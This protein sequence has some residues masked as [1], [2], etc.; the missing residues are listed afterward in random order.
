[1]AL[2][3]ENPLRGHPPEW[4][5]ALIFLK[6]QQRRDVQVLLDSGTVLD[7]RSKFLAPDPSLGFLGC[8]LLTVALKGIRESN[9]GILL[10][11]K[12]SLTGVNT[13]HCPQL[14]A[15]K[16]TGTQEPKAGEPT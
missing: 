8:M 4:L 7:L 6:G 16:Q 1:M 9:S 11:T 10:F 3:T 14:E 13:S 2:V 5:D 15:S 12:L